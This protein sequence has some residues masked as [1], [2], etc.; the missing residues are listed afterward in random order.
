VS[1]SYFRT[2]AVSPVLGRDFDESDDQINGA[3]V[4]ILSGGLWRRL[5][6]DGAILGHPIK[7]DDQLYTGIG[8]MPNSFENVLAPS[9]ELW[10]TLQ[11]D[12]TL[13]P[14]GPEWG[15]HL[16]LVGRLRAG[17]GIDQAK[18]ELST[19]AR[20]PAPEFFR[21]AHASLA[22]GLLM[23]SLQTD[24]TGG[25]R[26]AL[27]AIL[28]AV[29]LVLAIAC[30]NVINL[31]LA[32]GVHRR[33]EFALRST[34]GAARPRLIRQLLAENLLL[35]ALGGSLGMVMAQFGVRALVA[36]NPTDLPRVNAIRVD[37]II[38]VFALSVTAI[39]GLVVG[40]L[41]ALHASRGDLHL[42]TQ[43]SRRTTGGHQS[44]RRTLLV[45]EVAL[46][47]VLLVSAGLLLRS[48]QHLFAIDP[49]FDPSHLLTMQVQT[50]GDRFD[51]DQ[52]C[53]EFF[54]QSLEA[55]EHVPGV[56]AAAFTSQ[57]PLSGDL[58]DVY[59]VHFESNPTGQA[60]SDNGALRYIVNARYFETM[61]IPLRRGRLLD[62]HD[63]ASTTFS[64][65]ISESLAKR[66]FAGKD[67]TGQRLR[68]GPSDGPWYTIVGVVG[69][70]KQ[71]SLAMDQ[72][73]A[74]YITPTQW[75]LFADKARWLVV[76]VRGEKP[77]LAPTS[78]QRSGRL[79]KI[80]QSSASPPWTTCSHPPPRSGASL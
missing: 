7:L 4:A 66:R 77:A 50:F 14:Q 48:L 65:V 9:A 21:P 41:P 62:E 46:A 64:V 53:Q 38:F 30:V 67:P 32:R 73:D 76:R 33:G 3:K 52:V 80:S 28:G 26:P 43:G 49:G 58:E 25:V 69:N 16:R 8:V 11:Y 27:L 45:S 60:R 18:R 13:P 70:V 31:L 79:I 68:I 22:S 35:A 1:K 75:K 78:E 71:T 61:A 42:G 12:K 17:V 74:V 5:G 19:I 36:L 10:T 24:L 20:T 15:H 51:T 55:V 59:G 40:L 72:S 2:L 44:A 6:G 34:L 57:L 54:A 37:G 56:E 23:N 47:L 39:I 63:R 29:F